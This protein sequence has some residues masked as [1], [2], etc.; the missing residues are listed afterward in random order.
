MLGDW[1][2]GR[3]TSQPLDYSFN[4]KHFIRPAAGGHRAGTAPAAIGLRNRNHVA[5]LP[6]V[7]VGDG[8]TTAGGAGRLGPIST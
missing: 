8:A 2:F 5:G 7:P 1:S 4:R 3:T 6:D